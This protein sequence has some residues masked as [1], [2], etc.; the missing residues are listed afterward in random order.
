M[1]L[2]RLVLDNFRCYDRLEIAFEHDITIIVGNNGAGKTSILDG[3]AQLFGPFLQKL[4]T[5]TS[6]GT[7]RA[8][9]R[10]LGNNKLA[11]A[12]RIWGQIDIRTEYDA[13]PDEYEPGPVIAVSR[14][15]QR[16]K[17]AKT[18]SEFLSKWPP[19]GPLGTAALSKLASTLIDA[20]NN[21]EPYLLPLIVYY[22]TSRA[23]FDTP[24]RRRN[25]RTEFARFDGLNGALDSRASFKRVFEWFYFKE[26]EEARTQKRLRSFD[27]QDPELAQVRRALASFFPQ[28]S[29][30][31]TELKPL[32]FIVDQPQADGS[33][34]SLDLNQLSDGYR[35]TLA[36]VV[37]L[38]CRM[39]EANPPSEDFDPLKTE[40]IVL[41][42]EIDL[43]LHP[44]WQQ[45]IL[46]DLRRVFP[47]VQWIVT[48]HSAQVL[49]TVEAR[50][51]RILQKQGSETAIS[52]PNFALGAKSSQLLEDIQGVE[53][54]PPIPIIKK[55]K[56][57][58]QLIEQNQWDSAPA[59][60][61]RK[62]LDQW[63]G[64]N[65]AELARIDID[66]KMR[67]FRRNRT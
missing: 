54:R 57:Y 30:P 59:L 25:F 46:P 37:D 11:P 41:I 33:S 63:G 44:E 27:Y 32:R 67:A 38:T 21:D 45:R 36:L 43:H 10:L 1:K 17:S 14:N 8:D 16:D 22:G 51:I 55:L 31:R 65:E 26:N 28:F 64:N 23:V 34:I 4:P 48:T 39:V 50:C 47:N 42:D 3:I 9:L 24:L 5:I 12:L 61:L 6:L 19:P 20:E 56:Q 2:T 58:R 15:V 13:L 40:A 60:R 7:R 52:I 66:I 35:I 18:K 62:E 53:S 49:T 29:K